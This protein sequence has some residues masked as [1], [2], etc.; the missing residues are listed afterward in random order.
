MIHSKSHN[1]SCMQDQYF[2]RLTH[3]HSPPIFVRNAHISKSI[4]QPMNK[5]KFSPYI[6]LFFDNPLDLNLC[7]NAAENICISSQLWK[8]KV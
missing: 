1:W 6:F 3:I 5:N 4:H 2:S 8:H 7:H